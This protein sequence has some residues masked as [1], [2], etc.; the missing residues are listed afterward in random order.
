MRIWDINPGY[1][2][3]QSLLGEHCELHALSSIIGNCRKGYSRHP[4][5]LR[6]KGY[7]W[8]LS[9]RHRLLA[10]EMELR[11]YKHRSPVSFQEKE[12]D[13]PADYVDQPSRQF[14][15]LRAKYREKEKGRIRLPE[16]VQQI[17][18]HHKYSV[19]ARDESLYRKIGRGLAAGSGPGFSELAEVLTEI[20]RQEPKTRGIRNAAQHMWGHV[21]DSTRRFG[22]GADSWPLRELLREIQERACRCEE[23][24]LISSTAL[25]E[26]MAWIPQE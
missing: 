6:W 3:R 19:L 8:A 23:S 20:L 16:N 9:R 17:W 25:S 13:W 21:S 18:S 1:L 12:G 5:T 4:E 14:E 26:L 2:N 11:N 15:I 24:Y 7:G 10:A 22:P